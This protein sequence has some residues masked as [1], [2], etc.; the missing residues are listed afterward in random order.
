[1]IA[2]RQGHVEAVELLL[3][4]PGVD[5]HQLADVSGFNVLMV[6]AARGHVEVL[7]LLL[8]LVPTLDPN[9]TAF[10]GQT[11]LVLAIVHNRMEVVRELIPLVDINKADDM[12]MTVLMLAADKGNVRCGSFSAAPAWMST[13]FAANLDTKKR[14]STMRR[15]ER[16]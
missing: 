6:A 15:A 2:A 10:E 13:S 12:G 11:A 8:L 3:S 16:A 14:P 4:T 9:Y 7:R 5:P 1:M